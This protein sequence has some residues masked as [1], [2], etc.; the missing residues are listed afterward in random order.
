MSGL[1]RGFRS[2]VFAFLRSATTYDV[3]PEFSARV[4]RLFYNP[5]GVLI[6]AALAALLCGL[7]LHPQGFVLGGGVLAVIVLGIVW[8]WLSLRGLTGSIAF[9]RVR[10]SEGDPV[11][12]CLTLRNRLPWS[13]WGLA[14][15]YGF[16]RKI[17]RGP[18]HSISD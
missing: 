11:E 5:L 10:V 8:P 1:S 17:D 12:V 9:D 7:F 16:T 13:A 4:R 6:L 2:A 3:F 15:R 14:V 18:I